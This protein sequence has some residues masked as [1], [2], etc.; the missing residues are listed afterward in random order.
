MNGEGTSKLCTSESAVDISG[1]VA[2]GG[3]RH[4]PL[5]RLGIG[6]ASHWKT[7]TYVEYPFGSPDLAPRL[8]YEGSVGTA[9][10][11]DAEHP[12]WLGLEG[13][14]FRSRL[15]RG[16]GEQGFTLIELLIV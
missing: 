7:G 2:A 5:G 4:E 1:G 15:M 14:F 6:P 8:P 3:G 9:N 10:S 11:G 13:Y 12:R 16:K